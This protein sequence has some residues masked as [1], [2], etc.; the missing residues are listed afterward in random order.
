MTNVIATIL[1]AAGDEDLPVY[2]LLP[3]AFIIPLGVLLGFSFLTKR[4]G[5]GH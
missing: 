3:L 2:I 5:G 1:L 4:R